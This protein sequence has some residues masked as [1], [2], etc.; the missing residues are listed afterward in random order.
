MPL[1]VHCDCD[2]IF[3][4]Y[5][6][7]MIFSPLLFCYEDILLLKNCSLPGFVLGTNSLLQCNGGNEWHVLIVK[8]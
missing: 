1:S 5:I 2:F 6:N 3:K 4:I 8:N 7:H